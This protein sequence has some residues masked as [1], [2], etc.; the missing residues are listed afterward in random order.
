MKILIAEDE[1][2]IAKDYKL[3]LESR[4]H[5]VIIAKDGEECISKFNKIAGVDASTPAMKYVGYSPVDLVLLDYRMPKKDGLEVA[6]EILS[7]FPS[8]RILF[9]TAYGEEAT[10]E[11]MRRLDLCIEAVQKPVDLAAL[12]KMIEESVQEPKQE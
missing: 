3:F 8:Q 12:A 10:Q 2:L 11:S 1:P 7:L 5:K 9:V 4:G 6:S